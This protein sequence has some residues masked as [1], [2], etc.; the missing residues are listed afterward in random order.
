MND[1]IH[2]IFNRMW[3]ENP[4]LHRMEQKFERFAELIITECQTALKSSSDAMISREQA[5]EIIRK[6]FGNGK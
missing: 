3:F 4:D 1:K 6:H 5:C 2:E